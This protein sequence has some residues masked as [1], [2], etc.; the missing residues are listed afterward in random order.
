MTATRYPV[1]PVEE[2]VLCRVRTASAVDVAATV[3][4]S[5]RTVKRWRADGM[6]EQQA[7]GAAVAL[8]YHPALLW[9]TWLQEDA[10]EGATSA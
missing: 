6:S 7:D 2:I 8:G 3:G 9:P 5:P 10:T 1:T 4:V